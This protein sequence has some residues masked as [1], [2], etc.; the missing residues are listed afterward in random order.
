[1]PIALLTEETIGKIAAGEVVERPS[2][3][4]KELLENALDAGSASISIEIRNGGI[5]LIEIND[6]GSGM[7]AD[8]LPVSL[9]RHA[10]SK[11]TNFEDLDRLDTLG[12]RGEALPSIAAV[13]DLTIRTKGA[14]S[15]TGSE[16]H[17]DFGRIGQVK[18]TSAPEGTK[19]SVRDLFANVPARKKFLRQPSTEAAY[20]QRTVSAYATANPQVQFTL[21]IDGRR[22]VATDGSGAFSAAAVGAF[23]VEV[24]RAVI[25]IPD[26]DA[27]AR[28]PGVAVTGWVASPEVTRSHR[29]DMF[30]FVNGRWIQNRAL[31][32]ALEEAYHSLLMVGRHPIVSMR[33]EVDP[34]A[35]DVN[36]H[37]TKAEV[38]FVDE[39]AVC[40][41]VQRAAHAALSSARHDELPSI[42]FQPISNLER[43]SEIAIQ[44]N[45]LMVRR[46]EDPSKPDGNVQQSD[47]HHSGVP[48][49]RV[50]GQVAATYIIAE[51]PEGMYLIDQH[52]AHER[53]MY[54]KIL[55]QLANQSVDRQP[56]LDPLIVDL[57][58]DQLGAFDRS[59]DEL[60]EIGFEIEAFGN[61]SVAIREVPAVVGNIDI[62]KR[63]Q[64]ILQ[65][66]A[67][68]GAGT[69]WLD[70]VAVSAACHTSIRAG[71]ALS[72]AEM[73]E[74]IASL[75]RTSQPRACGHGRPTMLHMTQTDLEK[76]FSRR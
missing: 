56:L 22:A 10:T 31:S 53:V 61:G 69:S 57:S 73:R 30:F 4:V 71:Q 17:V 60:K 21:T 47:G 28:V 11:L 9:Q 26:P 68:G 64:Q 12:F 49:L 14:T 15:P 40:R 18:T 36:V 51:G 48:I 29:Q 23:G 70:S 55:G 59:R 32:F 63:L 75:E 42:Q 5:D 20:I 24:G 39:R 7:T 13:S 44:S 34:A 41:A 43:Q 8:E 16:I 52:A 46:A 72:L 65:E 1:M 50:L 38:K 33:I 76:Q 58:P 66:L 6:N 62:G 74:L 25:E 45:Q 54:E 35:V 19:I 27:I 2:S 37:P 67:E 3:V